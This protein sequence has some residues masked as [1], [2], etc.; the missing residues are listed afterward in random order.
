MTS[1]KATL[2]T[3]RTTLVGHCIRRI[4]LACSDSRTNAETTL[5]TIPVLQR[6]KVSTGIMEVSPCGSPS[7][8]VGGLKT[9]R[10]RGQVRTTHG[11][12]VF[13]LRVLRGRCSVGSPRNGAS[14]FE[15]ISEEL[16]RFR[17]RLR[18]GGCVRTI[19]ATC[20]IDQRDLRG[21]ITGVTIGTKVTEPI[22]EPGQTRKSRGGRGRSKVLASRGTLLA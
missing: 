13:D 3:K 12:F 22:T 9:R 11:K 4:C 2:A 19:T 18:H 5:H 17:S 1:L 16:L 21:V 10:C 7:R 20:Q 15:R 14:F 6:T 8:F